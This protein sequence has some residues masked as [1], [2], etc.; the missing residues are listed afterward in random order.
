MKRLSI[1][2]PA[3]VNLFLEI[4]KRRTDG[5]HDI[6]SVFQTIPLYDIL[7][8]TPS[9]EFSLC[10]DT[11]DIPTDDSNLIIKAAKLLSLKAGVKKGGT[12][13]LQK[14]IPA[15][16]GL[17]GGSSNAAATLKLLNQHWELGLSHKELAA[18][19]AEIGSDVPFFIYGGTCLC[20]GRGEIITPLPEA[21]ALP[22]GVISPP[23]GVSTPQAFSRLNPADFNQHNINDF[24]TSLIKSPI[25]AVAIYQAS[26]NHFEK[27]VFEH[28]PQ[29][30][31]LQQILTD[32]NMLARLSG[33]G[34]AIW[35]LNPDKVKLSEII[36]PDCKIIL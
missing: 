18:I 5:F 2:S 21:P 24:I 25:D 36:P 6:Q 1:K 4:I 17:G 20:E 34:S 16:G 10:T 27:S 7:E 22:L 33:S 26:F 23:W 30:R 19:G 9:A 8:F 31:S 15:C 13:H 28:T 35:I 32:N 14:H 29:Q 3:K 12:F 11:P